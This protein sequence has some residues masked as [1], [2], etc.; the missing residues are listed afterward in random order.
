MGFFIKDKIKY[1]ILGT[2]IL[3]PVGMAV[4]WIVQIGGKYFFV[5]LWVF[6]MLITLAMMTVYMDFIAPL[7]DKYTPLPEG[8]LR[9]KIES[10]AS[11]I[12]FPL[13]KVYIVE[14]SKRSTHSNAFLYGFFNNKRIVLFDT[15]LKGKDENESQ[16]CNDNEVIAVLG[17]ELGHW[18]L[19]HVVKNLIFFQ[20]SS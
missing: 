3:S 12:D 16:G 15:L 7:F 6:V 14:G 18:K 17:H 11:S 2:L 5:Y 9:T 4:T 20:V 10:L 1:L 8:E 13:K 19:N